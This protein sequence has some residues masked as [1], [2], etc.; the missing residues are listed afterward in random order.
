MGEVS[1]G[2]RARENGGVLDVEDP[3]VEER[4]SEVLAAEVD[5]LS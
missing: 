5:A 4:M 3:K 1:L 2:E